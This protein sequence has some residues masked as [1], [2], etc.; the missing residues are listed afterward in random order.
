MQINGFHKPVNYLKTGAV[1]ILLSLSSC[2]K[3]KAPSLTKDVVEFSAPGA[4]RLI[5]GFENGARHSVVLYT[6]SIKNAVIRKCDFDKH[7]LVAKEVLQKLKALP[8]NMEVYYQVYK[9]KADSA[10]QALSGNNHNIVTV[11]QGITGLDS[12][13]VNKFKK[14]GAGD[15]IIQ[16]TADSLFNVHITKKDSI[17]KNNLTK[18]AYNKMKT[19]EK[20]A[21]IS[22]LYNVDE[23]LLLKSDSTRA[24]P[25]SFFQCLE[26]GDRKKVQA[27][28]NIL[29][30]AAEAKS[31]IAKR[32]LTQLLVYGNGE[33]YN[34]KNVH[35]T[36]KRLLK[37][38]QN[39]KDGKQLIKEAF[40]MAEN[41]GVD[42]D[43]LE[44]SRETI[45]KIAV[46]LD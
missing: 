3:E 30:N 31:G 11:G 44:I 22:Y 4:A 32:D 15:Y 42:P 5:A 23:K 27:K 2:T 19:N 26:N 34:D 39:R 21:V 38:L 17:L 25:E 6:D 20:D 16:K 13:S 28:F 9:G 8:E 46:K 24:I 12:I 36:V 45:K 43:K 1:A 35:K 14:A 10:I 41:Y 18:L 40:D 29:P 37:V 7:K 33:I